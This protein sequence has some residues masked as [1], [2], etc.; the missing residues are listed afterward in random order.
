MKRKLSNTEW[1]EDAA[2]FKRRPWP[3]QF[4]HWT[5]MD[6]DEA[7][8]FNALQLDA[9]KTK[10]WPKPKVPFASR[11]IDALALQSFVPIQPFDAED[12]P[13]IWG[14]LPWCVRNY[15]AARVGWPGVCL[16]GF[17]RIRVPRRQQDAEGV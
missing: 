2:F 16:V 6:E 10:G 9:G 12:A 1:L 7:K 11:L 15:F 14:P 5:A 17:L 13:R 4:E 8:M 3:L